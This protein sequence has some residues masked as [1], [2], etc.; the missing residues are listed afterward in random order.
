LSSIEIFS[1]QPESHERE[2]KRELRRDVPKQSTD[3]TTP[4]FLYLSPIH[5][6][7]PDFFGD[8]QSH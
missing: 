8:G 1:N 2:Q 3:V 6:R 7:Q 4:G 5:A